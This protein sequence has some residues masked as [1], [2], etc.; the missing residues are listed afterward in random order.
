MSPKYSTLS[1]WLNCTRPCSAGDRSGNFLAA[2]A[3]LIGGPAGIREH[4]ESSLYIFSTASK[5]GGRAVSA[6]GF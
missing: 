5:A 1:M 6:R 3:S 2:W 4:A